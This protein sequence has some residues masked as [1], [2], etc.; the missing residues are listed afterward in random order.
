[1][2]KILIIE[3]DWDFYNWLM[4]LLKP[5]F[6]MAGA[7]T[8]KEGLE[9]LRKEKPDLVIL[10]MKFPIEPNGLP[11]KRMWLEVL[12]KIRKYENIKV[13]ILGSENKDKEVEEMVKKG[14]LDE[15]IM[16][17]ELEKGPERLLE[18]IKRVLGL[19]EEI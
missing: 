18:A 1:M 10:D 4:G 15:C 12:K 3:D 9:R 5:Y 7:M 2:K 16:K 8:A 14:A 11:K 17:Y 6:E 13:I 19:K